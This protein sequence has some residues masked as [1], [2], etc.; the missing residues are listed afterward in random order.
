LKET[1]SI[2]C[3]CSNTISEKT[4][5]KRTQMV[6]LTN[7]IETESGNGE[8]DDYEDSQLNADELEQ[9]R[10]CRCSDLAELPHPRL[11]LLGPTGVG[12]STL[13]DFQSV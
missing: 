1:T 5:R 3:F 4:T 11:L 12:K 10:L 13:G 9:S 6:F 7:T 8:Y 2:L